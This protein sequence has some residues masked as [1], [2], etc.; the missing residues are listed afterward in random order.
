MRRI[1]HDAQ[2]LRQTL[3]QA[4][5]GPQ[6]RDFRGLYTEEAIQQRRSVRDYSGQL[7]TQEEL[8]RLLYYTG[9]INADR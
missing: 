7:M 8:S 1:R 5:G 2:A 9:D 4:Q 6:D 3:R